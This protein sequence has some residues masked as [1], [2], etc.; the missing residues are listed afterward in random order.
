MKIK[1]FV[2]EFMLQSILKISIKGMHDKSK[3][4]NKMQYG[5]FSNKRPKLNILTSLE[6][7][8]RKN[9]LL[10]DRLWHERLKSISNGM[11]ETDDRVTKPNK[12]NTNIV[13]RSSKDI[14]QKYLVKNSLSYAV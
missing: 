8:F 1:L 4:A 12:T 14:T 3:S 7:Y 2:D 11:Y 5:L 10:K 13:K 9:V 6:K